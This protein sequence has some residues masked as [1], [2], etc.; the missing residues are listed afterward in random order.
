MQQII[1]LGAG[2]MGRS[3]MQLVNRAHREVIAFADNNPRLQGTDFCGCPVV[4]VEQAV[5]MAPDGILIAV[6]GEERTVQLRQQ[7][8]QLG[9]S[10]RVET[11]A[12]FSRMLDIRA[13]VF[14]RLAQRLDGI[15]GAAA[16]LGV[17]RGEFAREINRL[18]PQRKL[19]LFDTF[20]G[21][22]EKDLATER[23]GGYSKAAAGDFSDT[24]F[25]QLLAG[26]T[27]PEQIVIRKGYFP[28]TTAGLEDQFAFVSLDADLYAPTLC[29]LQ[30]FYPRMVSGGVILLHDYHNE[31][32]SG[33]RAAV[34]DYEQAHGSLLLLPVRDLHGSVM[35]IHP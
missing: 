8:Q 19:Y 18:M 16:E 2:Q 10:G 3:A 7:L 12:D 23:A 34:S 27:T 30:W 21:F 20:T 17:Y 1:L 9:Y 32:F 13:A 28:H 26:M 5:A 31:R 6:A 15:P 11:L 24:D 14:A 4:S 25:S 22:D 29:G 35:V 33:V